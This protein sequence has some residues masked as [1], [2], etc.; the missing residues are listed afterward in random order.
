MNHFSMCLTIK[1]LSFIST[2]SEFNTKFDKICIPVRPITIQYFIK[3][4]DECIVD[5][6]LIDTRVIIPPT[7]NMI[8]IS[9]FSDEDIDIRLPSCNIK[10]FIH[11][12]EQSKLKST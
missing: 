8:T 4:L 12:L 2:S 10:Q 6:E 7:R 5:K 3:Y 9:K 1:Q 11:Q